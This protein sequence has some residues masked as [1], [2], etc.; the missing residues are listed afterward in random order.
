[1]LNKYRDYS[2]EKMKILAKKLPINP[3]I[4]T[5]LTLI[6]SILTGTLYITGYIGCGGLLLLFTGFLDMVDGSI[7]RYHNK[8]TKFGGFLDSLTDRFSDAIIIFAITL[9]NYIHWTI[10]F[11]T[12]IGFFTVSYTRSKSESLGLKCDIGIAERAERLIIIILGSWVAGIL[13]WILG[14]PTASLILM[15]TIIIVCILTYYTLI[16]RIYYVWKNIN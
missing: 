9:G 2:E 7:A 16:E 3:N 1:M 14:F 12:I 11:I 13:K 6:L 4:I 15:Y 8:T 10:G 5:L